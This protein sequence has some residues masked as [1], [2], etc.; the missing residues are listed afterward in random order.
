MIIRELPDGTVEWEGT[1]EELTEW[2]KS[3]NKEKVKEVR[4]DKRKVLKG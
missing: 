1:P 2:E 4:K 3:H